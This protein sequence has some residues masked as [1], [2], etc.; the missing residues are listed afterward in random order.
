MR[1]PTPSGGKFASPLE[2][3]QWWTSH[4]FCVVPVPAR[5]KKPM[6]EA[7][8]LLRLTADALP[9]YFNGT[10]Q[11]IGVLLGEP[12]G[13]TDVDLDCPEALAA[14]GELLPETAMIFG[15]QSKPASH[16]FYHCVPPI[17]SK[18]FLDAVD[19]ACLVELR[20][21]KSDGTVGLQT[22][23]PP[24]IHPSGEPI[25][26]EPELDGNPA[27]VDA[28]RLQAAVARVAA[29]S[30]LARHWP[31][32]KA[33][34]NQTFI[35][36][37]GALARGGQALDQAITFHRA[38]YRALWGADADVEQCKA[39]VVSTFDKHGGGFPTTGRRS[40]ADLM[41]RRAVGAAFSWLGIL[42]QTATR[43][44][45]D[46]TAQTTRQAVPARKIPTPG[47]TDGEALME[48]E[49][50]K[51]PELLIEGLLPK[52]GLVLLG[53]RPKEGKSFLVIQIAISIFTG[54]ALGGWLKVRE[55]GRIQLWALE[56]K[57]GGAKDTLGKL[58]RG[59]RPDG[60]RDL[61][62]FE[63]LP[64]PLLQGGDQVIRAALREH[65]AEVIIL[66]SLFKLAGASQP[67][68]DIGQ[69]EYNMIDR[70]REIALEHHAVAIIVMHT[71]KGSPGGNPIE[72]LLGTTGISAAADVIAELKKFKSG[73]GKLT[74][75]GRGGVQGNYEV[76]RH[77]G[78]DE[79]GWTIQ[80]TCEQA[81]EHAGEVSEEILE[82]LDGQSSGTPAVIAAALRKSFRS[83]WNA[84]LRLQAKGKVIRAGKKW[85][86]VK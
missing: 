52:T 5:E 75:V 13:I 38:I 85:S 7:W 25:R 32:E 66:D 76:Q 9:Q 51:V 80:D 40:L 22:V 78:P 44:D 77:D 59:T 1:T 29:A 69:K 63:E 8:Q 58:L 12:Y 20:C 11:N 56:D 46:A 16:Y 50:L 27:N 83:V 64:V 86:L 73:Q 3:A 47:C 31:G 62:V 6:L 74:V 70:V 26:F 28:N 37:A 30:L 33:G 39:E 81:D 67:N 82:Y 17:R 21:Q 10:P 19:K 18:R 45:E 49:N 41:D 60:L 15:R 79:W 54:Q 55:T 2:A 71:R 34:R 48:D 35:A 61:K 23:V 53:G 42:Q 4:G 68:Y 84:L 57:K 43:R 14:A 24:G 36:L 72:N 65:P